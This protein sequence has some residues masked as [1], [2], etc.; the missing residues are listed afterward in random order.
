MRQV[1]DNGHPGWPLVAFIEAAIPALVQCR[2]EFPNV[3]K[4]EEPDDAQ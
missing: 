4:D 3:A 2:N 1:I